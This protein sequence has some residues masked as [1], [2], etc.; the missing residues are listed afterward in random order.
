CAVVVVLYG[1][2]G[3]GLELSLA[4]GYPGNVRRRR[5]WLLSELNESLHH[6]AATARARSCPGDHVVE[7]AVGRRIY[8]LPRLSHVPGHVLAACVRAFRRDW[9]H[10]GSFLLS[11]VSRRSARSSARECSRAQLDA[12]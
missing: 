8:A 5:S 1:C 6:L 12:R 7:C 9:R 2:H 10:L 3:M 4:G 11:L